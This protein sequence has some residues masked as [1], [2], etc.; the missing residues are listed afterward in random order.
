MKDTISVAM[1]T[2][3]GEKYLREQLDSLYNQVMMPDEVVVVDDCSTDNTIYILEEYHQKYNLKYFVNTKNLG[4]NKNFEKAI[5]NC[6]GKYI[7][8]SDQDDVWLPNKLEKSIIRLKEIEHSNMPAI[9]AAGRNDID[10][11]NK[12][13]I[14]S[15]VGSDY[16]HYAHLLLGDNIQWQG[17]T[18][19]MNRKL[20]E[21]ILPFPETKIILYDSYITLTA[22]LSASVYYIAQPLIH[23]RRHST[24]YCGKISNKRKIYSG[25]VEKKYFPFYSQGRHN[26]MRYVLNQQK[27]NTIKER[28]TLYYMILNISA[29]NNIYLKI[30]GIISIKSMSLIEKAN[31]VF[32]TALWR[33]IR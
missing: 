3:N 33:N 29:E 7:A 4:V 1:T 6:T 18:M 2:Y 28:L 26:N 16:N 19:V 9:V 32:H 8:L 13:L 17:C 5:S 21:I 23:Y 27:S 15:K 25:W 11:E 31:A 10:A 22:A 30:K 24:N 20:I 14:K 12:L